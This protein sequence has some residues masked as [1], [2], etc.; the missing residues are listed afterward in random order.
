MA[1]G[2][3]IAIFGLLLIPALGAQVAAAAGE[4][5]ARASVGFEPIPLSVAA[6]GA[7]HV[8]LS[9]PLS[10]SILQ[11]SSEGSP[12]TRPELSTSPTHRRGRS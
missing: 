4:G 3:R 9:D 10:D 11:F 12:P 2:R 1:L 7:G 8:Y 6:D 5:P